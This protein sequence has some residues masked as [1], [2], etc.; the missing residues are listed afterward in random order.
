MLFVLPFPIIDPVLVQLG[1][2]QI[3]WYGLAYVAGLIAGWAVLRRIL[4]DDSRWGTRPRLAKE[5]LD[6]LLLYCAIGVIAGGRLGNVLFYD[7]APYIAD[8]LKIF[9]TWEGGMAFHGGLIGAALGA[10]LFA[11]R[12][13]APLLTILDLVAL[14]A[15]IGLGLGRLANFVN[16]E[17]WGR[18]TDVPWAV[19]FPHADALPRHPSQIYEAGLEGLALFVLLW[20]AARLGAL[21]HPGLIAGLFGVGYS[22]ARIF[23]EF[24]R[25][26]DPHLED[27]GNGLTMGMVLSAPVF[28]IGLGLIGLSLRRLTGEPR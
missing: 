7:P 16:G 19:I 12:N 15:P 4:A 1:P 11:W 18:P 21:R 28:I 23:V 22:C 27:L 26:P 25:D 10:A 24:Y 14:V 17:L 13:K 2:L 8:P 9:R 6:D 5:S 3:H 20:T